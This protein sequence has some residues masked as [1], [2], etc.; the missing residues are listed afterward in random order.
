M[1]RGAVGAQHGF[2]DGNLTRSHLKTR[3]VTRPVPF[4]Q[5]F[6]CAATPGRN[7]LTGRD[8][9]SGLLVVQ[10]QPRSKISESFNVQFRRDFQY[11]DHAN[12]AVPVTPDNTDIFNSTGT[13][14]EYGFA[15]FD[16]TTA[17][18]IQ[19]ALKIIW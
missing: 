8:N 7:I 9:E 3:T 1:L 10:E 6:N 14:T 11:L 2:L 18:E 12:F 17:R 5:C 15:D 13:S 4:P 16:N 19:F